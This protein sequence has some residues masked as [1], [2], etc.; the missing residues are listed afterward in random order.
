MQ[1]LVRFE[2]ELVEEMDKRMRCDGNNDVTADV[3]VGHFQ[4]TSGKEIPTGEVITPG[5][6]ERLCT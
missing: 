6:K 3:R 1:V 4:C 2:N 5:K